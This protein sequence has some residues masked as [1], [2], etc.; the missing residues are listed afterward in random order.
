MRH[1]EGIGRWRAALSSTDRPYVGA[2]DFSWNRSRYWFAGS[3]AHKHGRVCD[4]DDLDRA[5]MKLRLFTRDARWVW[6]RQIRSEPG[7]LLQHLL[8]LHRETVDWDTLFRKTL[9]MM[10]LNS[11]A[12]NGGLRLE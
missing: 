1:P 5:Q 10:A 6:Q 2:S 12:D 11:V 7:R 9:E 3:G 4:P 8:V